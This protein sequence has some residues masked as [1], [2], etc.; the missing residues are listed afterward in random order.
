MLEDQSTLYDILEISPDA[1]PQEI[2]TAYLQAKMAYRRD[3]VAL[4]T[5]IS[6][7]E[8][9]DWLRKI[10]EAYQILSHVEK[11][12]EYDQLHGHLNFSSSFASP[13]SLTSASRS[14]SNSNEKTFLDSSSKIVSIDR[15]PP[16]DSET[17]ETALLVPPTTDFAAR[18]DSASDSNSNTAQSSRSA[19]VS[20]TSSPFGLSTND[21]FGAKKSTPPAVPLSVSRNQFSEIDASLEDEINKETEW[22][23]VFIR[24]IREAR[25]VSLE[26]L[27]EYSKISRSYITAIEDENYGRLPAPVYLRGFIIQV[28]KFLKLPHEK[29]A[30]AYMAR[31]NLNKKA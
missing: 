8:T 22:K 26:E 3:S 13:T 31:V 9:Q 15:V 21:P 19:T 5:L 11:R 16:M 20:S 10:E 25:K 17:A 24:R 4:Y 12:K 14:V 1:T 27:A 23:G 28:A 2:R 7:D 29:V 6:E 18:A 30:S